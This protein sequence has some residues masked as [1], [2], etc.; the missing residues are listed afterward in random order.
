L[1]I[2]PMERLDKH[3]F[4][5]CPPELCDCKNGNPYR[6][7]HNEGYSDGDLLP[8][9][10]ADYSPTVHEKD[11]D[12]LQ[13]LTSLIYGHNKEVG[14]WDEPRTVAHCLALIHSEISEAL[15]GDRKNLMDDHLPH[16]KMVE[17]EL[18][19]AMIR[20]FDLAGHLGCD[21]G[22]AI[23]EKFEYNKSRKD[24]KKENRVKDGGKKY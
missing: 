18:A 4:V 23:A 1:S 24:H 2:A 19:D 17:V 15:E 8:Q 10:D 3:C 7:Y 5:A 11:I 14:W 20:I 22:N 6:K 13:Y 16:R 12:S 21:L 9:A